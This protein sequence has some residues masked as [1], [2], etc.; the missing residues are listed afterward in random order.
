MNNFNIFK[1]TID[2]IKFQFALYVKSFNDLNFYEENEIYIS[3]VTLDESE[4]P[5]KGETLRLNKKLIE[6]GKQNFYDFVLYQ[7]FL[8]YK[9]N[10]YLN[11]FE[12]ER[13][14][15]APFNAQSVSDGLYTAWII[16]DKIIISFQMLD[17]AN[18]FIV[19]KL[20]NIPRE[21]I[22]KLEDS[23][24]SVEEKIA[25]KNEIENKKKAAKGFNSLL[26]ISDKSSGK[27]RTVKDTALFIRLFN[28]SMNQFYQDLPFGNKVFERVSS[29]Y[30]NI[31]KPGIASGFNAD[32]Q[33]ALDKALK[34]HNVKF[35]YLK[36]E[37]GS[38]CVVNNL[39]YESE[40]NKIEIKTK[41]HE[42]IDTIP[43]REWKTG[44]SWRPYSTDRLVQL[45]KAFGYAIQ[46]RVYIKDLN[47]VFIEVLKS[48]KDLN[49]K[50]DAYVNMFVTDE[51]GKEIIKPE[52]SSE[53]INPDF[54]DYSPDYFYYFHVQSLV[55]ELVD[56]IQEDIAIKTIYKY[57][58]KLK[59]Y[60]KKNID[61]LNS[62]FSESDLK[63][64]V[65][66][67]NKELSKS[68]ELITKKIIKTI[69]TLS[70]SEN[71]GILTDI[72]ENYVDY[73]K[74][75]RSILLV[76]IEDIEKIKELEKNG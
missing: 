62:I 28:N 17:F 10:D 45:L 36:N 39:D 67:L 57:S 47:S 25:I 4:E 55:T 7:T 65:L 61:T 30:L 5:I 33:K 26:V 48:A 73:G 58:D 68:N 59:A 76:F 24:I 29:N 42:V 71:F 9:R 56:G 12:N 6:S 23:E 50:N 11:F 27:R 60:Y 52:I 53:G 34:N 22:I 1:F 19:H 8:L 32:V 46:G 38:Y 70:K 74:D 64:Q 35:H 72:D 54:T 49:F 20:F 66:K 63:K 75:L 37:N 69:K 18:D 3:K 51:D 15:S 31:I 21:S 16:E 40:F 43:P 2:E 14:R 41:F 13:Y 44:K